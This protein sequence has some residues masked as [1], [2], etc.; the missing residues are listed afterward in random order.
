VTATSKRLEIIEKTIAAGSKDPFHHYARAME[1]RSLG[2]KDDALAA[3]A[4]MKADFA[5]YVPTYLMAAQVAHEL[6]DVASAKSWAEAG[7]EA[8]KKA[9]D[10]HA[11]SELGSFLSTLG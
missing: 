6:G 1:L 7:V 3:F 9:R 2:R 5:A 10:D 8:A 4:T 11:L